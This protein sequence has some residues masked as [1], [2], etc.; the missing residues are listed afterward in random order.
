M[1]EDCVL[2]GAETGHITSSLRGICVIYVA[3]YNACVLQCCGDATTVITYVE[4]P[5]NYWQEE[6]CDLL[7]FWDGKFYTVVLLF[8]SALET[9]TLCS[10]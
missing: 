9:Q 2:G 7:I 4:R 3:L 6:T 10:Y 8:T 5:H 1:D